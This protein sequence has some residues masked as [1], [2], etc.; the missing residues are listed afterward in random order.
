MFFDNGV[1]VSVGYSYNPRS[2]LNGVGYRP[3]LAKDIDSRVKQ[4]LKI[5]RMKTSK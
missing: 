3:A 1:F 2:K 5:L 4:K